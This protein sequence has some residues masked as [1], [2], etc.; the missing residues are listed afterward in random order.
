MIEKFVIK[1]AVP[2]GLPVR[3]L[4][5]EKI[6]KL[7]EEDFVALYLEMMEGYRNHN[8]WWG[9]A[10]TPSCSECREEINGPKNLRRYKG[11]SMHPDC[12]KRFY[13]E[14]ENDGRLMKEYFGRVA[15]LVID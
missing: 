7:S 5:Y 3:E 9:E 13:E 10:G 6:V 1:D 15:E 14:E 11:L 2:T 12:F 4:D 8:G